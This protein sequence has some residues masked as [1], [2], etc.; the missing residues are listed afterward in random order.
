MTLP[1]P[2]RASPDARDQRRGRPRPLGARV[3]L[4]E[5]VDEGWAQNVIFVYPRPLLWTVP[6]PV[7]EVLK[8]AA[9]P[10]GVEDFFDSVDGFVGSD[11][12]RRRGYLMLCGWREKRISERFEQGDVK[13]G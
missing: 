11:L 12:G 2:P 8:P 10:P 9:P 6:L 3:G 1:P 7:Y 5:V 4:V 13:G